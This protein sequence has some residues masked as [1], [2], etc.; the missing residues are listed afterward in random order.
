MFQL[1]SY[2]ANYCLSLLCDLLSLLEHCYART[3]GQKN[4]IAHSHCY[5]VFLRRFLSFYLR[6][7]PF[8]T[9]I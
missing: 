8:L 7:H 9:V 2:L 4:P 5:R 6:V 3:L 1:L